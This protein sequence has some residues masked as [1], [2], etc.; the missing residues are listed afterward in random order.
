MFGQRDPRVQLSRKL[1]GKLPESREAC[2]RA[3]QERLRS[4]SSWAAL[5]GLD[6][7]CFQQWREPLAQGWQQEQQRLLGQLQAVSAAALAHM[8]WRAAEVVK[9]EKE[10]E[11]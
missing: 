1:A 4:S 5:H 10:E 8:P 6:Q 2:E 3:E 7:R 9:A 11:D